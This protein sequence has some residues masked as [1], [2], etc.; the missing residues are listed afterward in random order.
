MQPPTDGPRSAYTT[1]QVKYL[2][3][4]TSSVEISVGLELLD[5]T[6]LSVVDDLSDNLTGGSVTRS[7]Y[8][9]IHGS[10]QFLLS[11]P[12]DWGS[13]I[14]RPYY[15]ITGPISSLPVTSTVPSSTYLDQYSD[16]YTAST[17]Y[18]ATDG[19]S[20]MRFNLGAYFLHTPDT[21]MS[22]SP[23]TYDVT[24][25]DILSILDDAIGDAYSI[26]AGVAYLDRVADIL[27]ARGVT[28]YVIDQAAI[29]SVLQSS[30]VY[31]LDNNV[32]WLTVVNDC[33]AAVGYQGIWSDWN[34]YLR[35][36]AYT[37][38]SARTP[39]WVLGVDDATNIIGQAVKRSH[40]FYDAPNRWVFYRANNTE[41]TAPVDGD[42]RYEYINVSIGETS[43]EARAGRTIT[44]V[45]SVDAADQAG[46]VAA[47][48]QTIDADMQTP[49]KFSFP[50]A[51]FPLAWH[52][53]KLTI[54]DGR[55]GVVQDVLGSS[56]TLPFDGSDMAMEVT[57][58]Q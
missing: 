4:N 21:D 56:W 6:D 46:L 23:P 27:T 45:V 25:Y 18:A 11:Q 33:L 30:K 42:G 10:A 28:Q 53:D 2:L 47:A 31:T 17:A 48:Q 7:S 52:F 1:A 34:G 22:T 58:I 35:C 9:N 19:L 14:V 12:L 57:V 5:V 51:P 41:D 32:T 29:G 13:S 54:A 15:Q 36:Q 43:Q 8:A 40:D 55:F 26:P 39:E 37:T 38:P 50:I 49:T 44:K 20:T 24:G 3:E 16:L